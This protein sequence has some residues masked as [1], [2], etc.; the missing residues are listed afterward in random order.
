MINSMTGFARADGAVGAY[1]WSWEI[2]SVNAKG[3][4]L[5]CRL[6]PGTDMLEAAVRDRIAAKIKRGAVTANLTLARHGGTEQLVINESALEQV[7]ALRERFAGRV[8]SGPPRLESLL[9]VRG[10]VESVEARDGEAA[11]AERDAALLATL[12]EALD[13]L[14][15]MRRAEGGRL[16]ALLREQTESVGR[17]AATA[18]GLSAAQPER[19]RQRLLESLKLLADSRP[20]LPEERLAQEVALLAARAD[21]REEIDRLGAHCEAV[22]EALAKGGVAGRRLDFLSQELNR[23]ANT[24]CSKAGDVELTRIGLDLKTAIDQF[25][26]QV[27][28]VE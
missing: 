4:D 19:L 22:N 18:R 21:I 7:L 25:R 13:R 28:N 11:L 23:E 6:A 14:V 3:L 12:D 9:A 17:L 10:V 26:E 1:F 2:K 20:P 5:R 16:A 15:A 27:Q 8:E 24:L